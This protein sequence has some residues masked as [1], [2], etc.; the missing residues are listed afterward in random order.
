MQDRRDVR[1]KWEKQL[2]TGDRGYT[3]ETEGGWVKNSKD[4]R[5]KNNGITLFYIY[6]KLHVIYISLERERERESK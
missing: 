2:E 5:K 1:E 3:E 4:V 6:L